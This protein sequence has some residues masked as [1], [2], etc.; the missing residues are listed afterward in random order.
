[1]GPYRQ[2]CSS[3]DWYQ[4]C[5]WARDSGSLISHVSGD[6]IADIIRW[7]NKR[8]RRESILATSIR[9]VLEYLGLTLDYSMQGNVK[10]LM[11]NYVLCHLNVRC[12]FI[13]DQIK[14]DMWRLHSV[15]CKRWL[16]ISWWNHFKVLSLCVCERR[17]WTCLLGE[18]ITFTGVCWSNTWWMIKI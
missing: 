17:Y 10:I 6:V 3:G 8:F 15:L 12:Y 4:A 1:M 9:K 5:S 7:L 11:Y 13:T 18:L 16:Q 2:H 14:K